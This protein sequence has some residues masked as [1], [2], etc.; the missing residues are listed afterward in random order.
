MSRS[1]SVLILSAF[2]AA[3]IVE[4]SARA[5]GPGD[6]ALTFESPCRYPSGIASDGDRLYVADWRDA[7]LFE[8]DPADGTVMRTFDAPTLNPHGLTFGND[9]LWISDDHTGGI[10]ALDLATGIAETIFQ[11]PNRKATGLA[12]HDDVLFI[13][14]GGKIYRV[15]PDDGTILGYC[16]APSKGSECLAHDGSYL[17]VSDRL[18]DELY[19]CRPEDGKVISILA[20]PGPYPA[21]IAWRDD[22]LI[23]I[24][25]QTRKISSLI[26]HDEQTYALGEKRRARVEHLWEFANYGPGE[27]TALELNL[28]IPMNLRHQ[29]LLSEVTFSIEPTTIAVDTWGQQCALFDLGAVPPGEKR[30]VVYSVEVEIAEINHLIIPGNVGS[31]DQIPSEI[32]ERYT[33]DSSRYRYDTPF[34]RE[35]VEKV[36][37]DE[38]NPY[39]IA[40]R[41]YDHIISELEYQMI[42]GW[43]IPEVVLKRG[44]GSCSEYTYTFIAMCRAAGIPA[45]YQ[46]SISV[47]GD[48]AS[49]D[50][51]FH[52]WA[53]IYLPGYGWIPVDANRGDKESAADQARGFGTLKNSLLITTQGGGGSEYLHWGYNSYSSYKARGYCNVEENTDGFWEPLPED[54]KTESESAGGGGKTATLEEC[55]PAGM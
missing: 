25:F 11:A 32:R 44:S 38:T 14:A 23:N 26:I 48:D 43:D 17:W 41:I 24:D 16:D 47:R 8:I 7:K 31:L 19:M 37:G 50:E 33:A 9:R 35:S 1:V 45:R 42:G 3:I 28:A 13:C 29:T 15:T 54:E 4:S 46:G 52:R 40:R 18:N 22:H 20:S 10:Y 27:V 49:I 34:M 39:W 2:A 30:S 21:G 51:A 55:K 12:F 36:V 6:V 53:E 5:A